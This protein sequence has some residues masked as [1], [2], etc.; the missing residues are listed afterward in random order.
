MF[1]PLILSCALFIVL[2]LT[3]EAE[4]VQPESPADSIVIDAAVDTWYFGVL[5]DDPHEFMLY[6]D[7]PLEAKFEVYVPRTNT[8]TQT[9]AAIIVKQATRGVTEVARLSAA[10][11]SWESFFD[12]S[13]GARYQRGGSYSGMLEP[14]IYTIEVHSP[15][16]HGPYALRFGDSGSLSGL[17]YFEK[18]RELYAVGQLQGRPVIAML[19]SPYL[20][21]PLLLVVA[22][23]VWFWRRRKHA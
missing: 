18:L 9:H 5:E 21:V 23:G 4:I 3:T 10:D 19:Y 17:G 2:P 11:A 13:M 14:G 15:D 20:Y 7:K 6:L 8:A 12:F 1:R 16:N 22:V